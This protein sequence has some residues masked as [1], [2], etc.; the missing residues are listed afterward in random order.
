MYKCGFQGCEKAY[1]TLNHLNAHVTMQSHGPK[2]TPEGMFHQDHS[3]FWRLV[4]ETVGRQLGALLYS[5]FPG[6]RLHGSIILAAPGCST[7]A[8]QTSATTQ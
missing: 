8:S 3:M 7:S 2:R 6:S 5:G 1:G 4:S